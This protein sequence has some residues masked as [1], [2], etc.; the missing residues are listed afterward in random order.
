MYSIVAVL[1]LSVAVQAASRPA[2]DLEGIHTVDRIVV[3]PYWDG[4]RYYQ[5]LVEVSLDGNAWTG[6]GDRSNNRVP[7][8]RT[9]DEFRFS[10]VRCRFVRVTMLRNS[11]NEGVH[12]VEVQVFEASAAD[13]CGSAPK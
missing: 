11:A 12:L 3:F 10:P 7:A 4:T 8:A 2:L 1:C 9:G 13:P 5:Y 6:V